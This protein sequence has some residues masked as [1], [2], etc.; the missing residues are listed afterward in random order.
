MLAACM[1]NTSQMCV[2]RRWFWT[3]ILLAHNK[4]LLLSPPSTASALTVRN[5]CSTGLNG[6]VLVWEKV[7]KS[8]EKE[9]LFLWAKSGARETQADVFWGLTHTQLLLTHI[10]TW[11]GADFEIETDNSHIHMFRLSCKV[12]TCTHEQPQLQHTH[13]QT[14]KRMA[15]VQRTGLICVCV[16]E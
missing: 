8:W 5:Y 16:C 7:A 3:N 9:A 6:E 14:L 4:G 2:S 10:H 12:W 15:G 11:A 1:L 13:S